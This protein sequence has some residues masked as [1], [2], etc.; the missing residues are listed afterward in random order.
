MKSIGYA[1]SSEEHPPTALVSNAR[2]A[3]EAGFEFALVSDHYHP[4]TDRQGQSP[5]VWTVLGAIAVRTE[6]LRVG[7]GVTCPLLR[8]HP[9]IIAQAA[10]TTAALFG[11]RFFLGV[12]AGENLNEHVLGDRW[13]SVSERHERLREAIGI[14]RA[15]WTG[16][17][18]SHRGV[19]YTVD[20][21]RLYTLPDASPPIYV[22]G[23]GEES[24]ALAAEAGDGFISTDP[25]PGLVK[26]FRDGGRRKPTYGQV[27]VCYAHSEKEAR[28]TVREWWPQAGL[29]GDLSWELKIPSLVEAACK[30]IPDEEIVRHIACG[31]DPEVHAKAIRR[32]SD[33]GFDHVYVHQVGPDQAGFLRFF[34][35]ELRHRL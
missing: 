32:F 20:Q 1:L 12:G 29:A 25:D 31:P 17:Q 14:L 9:A 19:W 3:E 6:K 5:F 13:P 2:L 7:T 23:S 10:A 18:V 35:E 11:N 24:A 21:A 34:A 16:E 30:P 22:A 27:T 8:I 15:L 26:G 4:W 28:N 33:A